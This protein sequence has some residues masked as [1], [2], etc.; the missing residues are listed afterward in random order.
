MCQRLR[1]SHSSGTPFPYFRRLTHPNTFLSILKT[2]NLTCCIGFLDVKVEALSAAI[3]CWS[4]LCS[5][6]A[7]FVGKD[8]YSPFGVMVGGACISVILFAVIRRKTL[9]RCLGSCC[10]SRSIASSKSP[11][12]KKGK[13]KHALGSVPLGALASKDD[14]RVHISSSESDSEDG[15]EGSTHSESEENFDEEKKAES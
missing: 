8:N 12:A 3:I 9:H 1:E 13:A 4:A 10:R 2:F 7:H 5:I 14:T 11:K 15:K 6:V